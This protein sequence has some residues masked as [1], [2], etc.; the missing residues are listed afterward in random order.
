M[1]GYQD[2]ILGDS[3]NTILQEG[4]K[5]LPKASEYLF[6]RDIAGILADLYAPDALLRYSNYVGELTKPL[7]IT[8]D[9]NPDNVLFT[10][11]ALVQSP[12]PTMATENGI[13]TENFMRSLQRD[14]E[15][16]GF[17][18]NEK[19]VNFMSSITNTPDY[20]VAVIQPIQQILNQYGYTMKIPGNT[21]AAP[22]PSAPAPQVDSGSSYS[23]EYED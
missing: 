2:L 21:P 15:L 19:I 7:R 3:L 8:S 16:G 6:K 20:Y 17:Q 12:S 11:P 23:D 4:E 14:F 10:I 13:T 5:L 18:V 1:K 9:D 22:S